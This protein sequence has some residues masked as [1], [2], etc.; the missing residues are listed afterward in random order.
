MYSTHLMPASGR[1]KM[2]RGNSAVLSVAVLD[3]LPSPAVL[4]DSEGIVRLT[5]C[6]WEA[7]VET[8]DDDRIEAGV[9]IDYFAMARRAE[10]TTSR[11]AARVKENGP[12]VIVTPPSML[13]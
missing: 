4:L 3:A 6:A 2:A 9:G 1:R 5:N 8:V 10:A 7:A 13:S 12:I 11:I